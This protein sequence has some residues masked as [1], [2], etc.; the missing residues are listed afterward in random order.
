MDTDGHQRSMPIWVTRTHSKNNECFG[1][2]TTKCAPH[3]ANHKH[4]HCQ[5]PAVTLP[6]SATTSWGHLKQKSKSCS[7]ESS[8]TVLLLHTAGGGRHPETRRVRGYL[9]LHQDLSCLEM[10]VTTL[11]NRLTRQVRDVGSRHQASMYTRVGFFNG[12]PFTAG[13]FEP[14]SGCRIWG[15]GT[16]TSAHL[17]SRVHQGTEIGVRP[18]PVHACLTLRHKSLPLSGQRKGKCAVGQLFQTKATLGTFY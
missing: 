9:H 18:L 3:E 8:Q 7:Q 10:G 6:T 1:R 17:M 13:S 15:L 11:Q 14:R 16:A 5:P 4:A 2:T 12:L